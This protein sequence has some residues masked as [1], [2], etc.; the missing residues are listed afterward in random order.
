MGSRTSWCGVC[1]TQAGFLTVLHTH[2]MDTLW[3]PSMLSRKGL[4]CGKG[5]CPLSARLATLQSRGGV[6]LATEPIPPSHVSRHQECYMLTVK[7]LFNG[8]QTFLNLSQG[9]N[10]TLIMQNCIKRQFI[11]LH[12]L[13]HIIME[14]ISLYKCQSKLFLYK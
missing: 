5:R 7:S 8:S 13:L 11:F 12:H 10:K 3:H 1:Q 9:F 6:T 2:K 4:G 14:L